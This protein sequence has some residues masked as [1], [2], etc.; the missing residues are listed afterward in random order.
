MSLHRED[1][2]AGFTG[3]IVGAIVLAAIVYGIVQL[4]NLKY[5]GEEHGGATKAPAAATGTGA[6]H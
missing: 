1:M 4:T 2:R 5:A 6:A 3:L